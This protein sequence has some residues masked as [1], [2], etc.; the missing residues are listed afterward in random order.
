MHG[1]SASAP[2]VL[3]GI[4]GLVTLASPD[5][6]PEGASPRTYDGD[7]EVGG[8][9]TRPGLKSAYT[10]DTKITGPGHHA[11][12]IPT[13]S[14]EWSNPDNVLADTGDY[15]VVSLAPELTISE[16][17]GVSVTT[18]VG[19]PHRT[20]YYVLVT[21]TS[22]TPTIV[23]GLTYTFSGLTSFPA[24]NGQTL[25]PSPSA[26]GPINWTDYIVPT[27]TQALFLFGALTFGPNAETGLAEYTGL[28]DALD[29]TQ[30]DLS[31]PATSV[32]QG[33]VIP[34]TAYASVS[35][36]SLNIQM[37][38]NE[39]PAGRIET[40]ALPLVPTVLIFGSSTDLFLSAWDYSDL[41]NP[42]FGIRITA[43][44]NV[45]CTVSVGYA[46]LSCYLIPTQCNFEFITP[47]TDQNGV[48]KNLSLD[49]NGNFW[50]EDV[51]NNPGVLSLAA[52]GITPNSRAVAVG[53][54]G[55]EYIAFT[56]GRRGSD[57]PI[58]YT[59]GWI[60]RITQVGPGKPQ[61]SLQH[62]AIQT[63]TL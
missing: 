10:Y 49:A 57:Q 37:L 32:P 40:L 60:D 45:A 3:S 5:S 2:V 18:T 63:V 4:G 30:F 41:N 20:F 24:L 50:V 22:E 51:T 36:A 31:V 7:Y 54:A 47:F 28:S 46:P 56:N 19:T 59:S 29:V 34:I 1:S 26:G 27:S 42:D 58:Q 61:V 44:S 8:W 33:F 62:W 11:A 9:K 6:V 38:K 52:E 43:S 53:G 23:P 16:I 21:F 25:T 48:V 39:I 13:S 14:A 15:A 17:Q 12:D 55:V 35:G